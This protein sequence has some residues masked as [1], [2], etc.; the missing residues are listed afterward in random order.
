MPSLTWW[1]WSNPWKVGIEQRAD[2]PAGKGALLL[3]NSLHTGTWTFSWLQTHHSAKEEPPLPG[4]NHPSACPATVPHPVDLKSHL[5][6]LSAST[7]AFFSR[8]PP[9]YLISTGILENH[10]LYSEIMLDLQKSCQAS[11][12]GCYVPSPI[13]RDVHL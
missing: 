3:P 4:Q 13:S 8:P 7:L 5:A 12:E 2:P 10:A 11:P 9:P 1:A 6:G